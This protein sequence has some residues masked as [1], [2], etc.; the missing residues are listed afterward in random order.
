M[1]A[2]M[3]KG[4]KSSNGS[5]LTTAAEVAAATVGITATAYKA[6]QAYREAGGADQPGDARSGP[7]SRRKAPALP[8]A[9][10]DAAGQE[11][12]ALKAH[13]PAAAE[14]ETPAEDAVASTLAAV[15]DDKGRVLGVAGAVAAVTGVAKALLDLNAAS[16][17]A[18]MGLR[19]IGR[20]RAKRIVA[21]RPFARV[22]DLK[23]VLPKR[24]YKAVR[25]QLTV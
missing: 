3:A 5:A 21:H 2:E 24:V 1:G 4:K 15:G 7:I 9:V 14:P 23:R 16:R 8:K 17:D 20:K 13:S 6:V 18:L 19:K 22:K 12:H 11:A 10:A 25:H